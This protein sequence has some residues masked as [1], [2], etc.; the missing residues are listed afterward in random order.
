LAPKSAKSREIPREF[1]VIAGQS[2]PRSSI[3]MSTQ[4]HKR[5][6]TNIVNSN[7]GRISYRFRDID[8]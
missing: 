8:V 2:H 1:K 4:V 5:L 7:Y 3:L 6:P